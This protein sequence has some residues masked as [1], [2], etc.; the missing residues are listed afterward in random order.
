MEKNWDK[1]EQAKAQNK[2]VDAKITSAVRGGVTAKVLGIR[3][4]I[5]A[6][7]LDVRFVSSLEDYVGKEVR[8]E[9]TEINRSKNRAILSVKAVLKKAMEEK[10]VKVWEN[11]QPGQIIT[12][13]VRRL[14]DFGAFVDLGGVD[15]LVHISDLAWTKVK[16]PSQ[17]V[18]EG[19]MV[20]VQVLDVNKDK[21]RISLGL[22]QTLANPWEKFLNDYKIGDIIDAKVTNITNFGAFAEIIPGVE[23]LIHISHLSDKYISKVD[24]AVK[25]GEIVKVKI[26]EIN[27][28]KKKV[29]L[30]KKDIEE[31]AE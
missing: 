26:I 3:A 20:K 25:S 10:S 9:V 8:A 4:F 24:Q 7:L 5:P 18:S 12:G 6:S 2:I 23:G 30:S 28:E 15:G 21:G 31:A 11:L 17:V 27:E 19:Q 22:K 14:T 16:H 13:T 29:S 1:L